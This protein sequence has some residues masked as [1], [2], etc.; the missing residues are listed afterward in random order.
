[1]GHESKTRRVGR[2]DLPLEAALAG[3][4]VCPVC[5]DTKFGSQPLPDGSL[6]R[7]CHGWQGD[8]TPCLFKWPTI[9]DHKYFHLPL[10]QIV[11]IKGGD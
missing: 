7:T 2:L 3:C 1:M 8:E 11:A 9:D 6:M 10:D 5:G 4:M